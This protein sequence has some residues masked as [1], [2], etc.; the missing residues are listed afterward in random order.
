[1]V[2]RAPLYIGC[3]A[4][5][6]LVA[7]T[8]RLPISGG[9]ESWRGALHHQLAHGSGYVSAAQ[10]AGFMG[11]YGQSSSAEISAALRQLTAQFDDAVQEL[12]QE[13]F[14]AGRFTT[15]SDL[16]GTQSR[17]R[18]KTPFLFWRARPWP[19]RDQYEFVA[20]TRA[21]SPEVWEANA[22]LCYLQSLLEHSI[23]VRT[24][25]KGEGTK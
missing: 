17:V 9:K 25:T 6:C 8:T 23:P 15:T 10:A 21:D 11:V 12:V 5:G 13:R 14:A 16:S 22:E 20:L 1:M 18:E 4:R 24:S 19:R 3:F 7:M 2:G